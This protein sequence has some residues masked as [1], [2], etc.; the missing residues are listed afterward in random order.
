MS[1]NDDSFLPRRK[2]H[3]QLVVA[4]AGRAA[5]EV[6]LDGEF[7]Q[8]ASGDLQGATDLAYR[9]VTQYGMTR[10]GY[11]VR[12]ASSATGNKDVGEVVEELLGQ[13]HQTA[14]ELVGEHRDFLAAVAE[15]LLEDETLVAAEI[16]ALA[17][18]SGVTGPVHVEVPLPERPVARRRP[19]STPPFQA[20]VPTAASVSGGAFIPR[21]RRSEP[22]R[23]PIGAGWGASLLRRIKPGRVTE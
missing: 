14:T 3:A 1:G 17:E 4:L 16:A 20:P 8:G 10:L 5:E 21:Q 18:R 23:R 12:D 13:A 2:A 9:M 22:V 15:A 19:E 7:T 6:L 11:Q